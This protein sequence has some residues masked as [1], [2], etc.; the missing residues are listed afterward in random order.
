MTTWGQHL[1][2]LGAA[3]ALAAGAVALGVLAAGNAVGRRYVETAREYMSFRKA[4]PAEAAL[5][6]ARQAF[7][8][9]PEEL[10]LWG[11]ILLARGDVA[12]AEKALRQAAATSARPAAALRVLGNRLADTPGREAEGVALL[13]E[14]LA[15]TPPPQKEAR[16]SWLHLGQIAQRVGQAATAAWALRRSEE[17]GDATSYLVPA[18]EETYKA[19]GLN[20]AVWAIRL[21]PTL[22]EEP[23]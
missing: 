12:G 23:K 9:E 16:W 21:D 7:P 1:G 22:K 8:G 6:R 19:L 2:R 5:I 11:P 20:E 13:E 4:D 3:A 18:L 15:L 10:A 17:A 14:A